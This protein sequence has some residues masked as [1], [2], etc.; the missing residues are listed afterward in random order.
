MCMYVCMSLIH[1]YVY[2]SIHVTYM[3]T[4]RYGLG[5]LLVGRRKSRRDQ[6]SSLSGSVLP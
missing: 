1:V 2:L 4:Y 3:Q 5:V 6:P